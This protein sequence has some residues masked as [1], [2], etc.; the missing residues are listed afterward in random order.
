MFWNAWLNHCRDPARTI[1]GDDSCRYCCSV[2]QGHDEDDV[3]GNP[4][5]AT[6]AFTARR[7]AL[8]QV[9]EAGRRGLACIG[10]Q[11]SAI[12]EQHVVN[13]LAVRRQ[14]CDGHSPLAG[15]RHLPI[16]ASAT[17]ERSPVAP[18]VADTPPST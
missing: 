7:A 5:F 8:L 4:T 9:G 10:N 14:R 13:G 3:V 6:L 12:F 2:G 17:T 16:L 18:V 15:G 11:H 1:L